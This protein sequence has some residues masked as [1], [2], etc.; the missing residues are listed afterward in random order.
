MHELIGEFTCLSRLLCKGRLMEV[1]QNSLLAAKSATFAQIGSATQKV[2][3][4]LHE[5]KT[6]QSF[7]QT[8]GITQ[9]ELESAPES[10]AT[11]AYGGYIIDTGVQGVSSIC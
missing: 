4:L 5:I 7:C 2:F 6:H 8:L 3:D 9:E 10:A 11:T 1:L